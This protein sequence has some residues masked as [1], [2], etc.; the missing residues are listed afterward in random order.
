MIYIDNTYKIEFPPN[1]GTHF[2]V[3]IQNL[4]VYHDNND[5]NSWMRDC[6]H[7][8]LMLSSFKIINFKLNLIK[9]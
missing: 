4:S 7:E 5:A 6:M 3:N 2:T 8:H 9:F 1:V